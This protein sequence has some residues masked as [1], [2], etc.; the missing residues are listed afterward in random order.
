MNENKKD[1]IQYV[2]RDAVSKSV[3]GKDV[4]VLYPEKILCYHLSISEGLWIAD[5][6]SEEYFTSLTC[7]LKYIESTPPVNE[8]W[9]LQ[10]QSHHQSRTKLFREIKELIRQDKKVKVL[11]KPGWKYRELILENEC[12]LVGRVNGIG[13]LY[14]IP[15]SG[16]EGYEIL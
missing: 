10:V 15:V 4:W 11:L 9:R 5:M 7:P 13:K 14:E 1:L 6:F 8:P 12:P 2:S 16:I 3:R